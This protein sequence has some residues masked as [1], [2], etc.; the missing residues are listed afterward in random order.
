MVLCRCMVTLVLWTGPEDDAPSRTLPRESST[1]PRGPAARDRQV[2]PCPAS[3]YTRPH[4]LTDSPGYRA[5][6]Q[7]TRPAFPA[8][9]ATTLYGGR[10]GYTAPSS[11]TPEIHRQLPPTT[12]RGL[13]RGKR[14]QPMPSGDSWAP[15]TLRPLSYTRTGPC[16]L[17]RARLLPAAWGEF[18]LT[19]PPCELRLRHLPAAEPPS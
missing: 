10:G 14:P 4:A 3:Q 17:Y 9:Y 11:A 8:D 2:M 13:Q 18:P 15:S 7:L 1:P 6:A 12:S 5:Q 16:L 19:R